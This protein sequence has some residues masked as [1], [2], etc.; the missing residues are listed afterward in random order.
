MSLSPRVQQ[1][2]AAELRARVATLELALNTERARVETERARADAAVADRERLRA[3]YQQLQIELELLRRRI[4]VA[5]SEQQNSAQLELEFVA[6]KKQLDELQAQLTPE[7]PAP[8]TEPGSKPP[9]KQ[10]AKPTGR[11][12]LSKLPLLEEPPCEILDPLLEGKAERIGFEITYQI[13]W[14]KPAVVRV[15]IARAKY[16]VEE[17]GESKL[18]VAELPPTLL[19]RCLAAP[20]ML[21]R[22][23]TDKF[24]DGLPLYRQQERFARDGLSLDRGTMCRWIEDVGMSCGAVVLAMR[25]DAMKAFCIATDATGIAIQPEPSKDKGP[26]PC[27]RGHFFVM[28]ADRDHVLFEYTPRETSAA[29]ANMFRGYTGYL[30]ADAKSVYDV[31]YRTDKLPGVS[32]DDAAC[33]EVGCWAHARRKFF[34][35][36]ISKDKIAREALYRIQR[37]FHLDAQWE[38]L[39]PI[40]RHELRRQQSAPEVHS[41]FEWV[42]SASP[43]RRNR[44]PGREVFRAAAIT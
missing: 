12:D 7:A 30:Q 29:V 28:V 31:L 9:P 22:I 16:R 3:A 23:I 34:E 32:D 2:E 18:V 8:E 40:Q 37:I 27:R 42:S 35:A 1:D 13:G 5:K 33:V 15:P 4:F 21:A 39:P 44:T 43:I 20:S 26:R 17:D 38:S 24:A 41:F 19:K 36:A 6:L 11:R 14:R 10:R 25:D